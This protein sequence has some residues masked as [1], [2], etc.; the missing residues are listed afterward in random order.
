MT[1]K[2]PIEMSKEELEIVIYALASTSPINKSLESLQYL[3][4]HR[5]NNKLKDYE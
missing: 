4:Y 2:L 3:L 5:L 1:P